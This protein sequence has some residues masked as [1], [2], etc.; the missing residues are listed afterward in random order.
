MANQF[1]VRFNKFRE[2]VNL[3]IYDV[4]PKVLRK[5]RLVSVPLSILA[6]V[7][8]LAFH[9]FQLAEWQQDWVQLI[10][11]VT[12]G[13]YIFKYL[14][15]IF[16]S[17]E[18][19]Q[20]IKDTRWEALLM[21]YMIIN[22]VSINVF[23]FELIS[24]VGLAV[25]IKEL[26]AFFMVLVQ[27]YFL[28]F[29]ALEI[30]KATRLLPNLKLSPA[31]MLVIS[32]LGFMIIGAGL[33]MLPEMSTGPG[34]MDFMD[35]LFTSVSAVSVTGLNVIDIT[36][37]LSFKGHL[38]V[39]ILI[40]IGGLNFITFA[41]ML[42]MLA[43]PSM[44]MRITSMFGSS[45]GSQG[46]ANST[47]L[48]KLIIRFSL[49]FELV[50]AVFLFFSW[51]H[52]EFATIGD[53]IF[54]SI[55]HAVSAFNNAG[56][57]LIPDGMANP[58]I[59]QNTPFVVIIGMAIILGGLGFTAIHDLFSTRAHKNRRKNP[60]VHIAVNTKIAVYAMAILIP[61]GMLIFAL[62]E[63]GVTLAGMT[64]GEKM[65]T[66]F[67]QSVTL[68]TAGFN[69]VDIG[70]LGLSTLL[71]FMVFMF[72]GGSSG[73]TAG[74]I[75]TSTFTLV[76]LNAW[77]T[78]RGRD[79]V[80]FAK[81]TIP[82]ELLNMAASVFLFSASSIFL[83]TIL[84]SFTD[85]HLGLS[86]LA[87]EQISAFCTVGLSTGITPDLSTGGQIILMTSMLIGRV[88]TVTLAFA[89]TSGTKKASKDYQYPKA[90]VQVG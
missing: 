86:R 14:V 61:T 3:G 54:Y 43:N 5:L 19:W 12:I 84:L 52:F 6:V 74:G 11:Q 88:G 33:L 18:P 4:K 25:G 38:I 34:S 26:D 75:K 73:S 42:A 59:A 44:S 1:K 15:D 60:W 65:L 87:F 37:I 89:L 66:S 56:F 78:I 40:Q 23:D 72:I 47:E 81:T 9:G 67:F 8:L 7:S 64:Y 50:T 53:Q 76:F 45:S 13:F 41:S 90:N 83:G 58:L 51:G 63:N 48:L 27:I 10:L 29:V 70:S 68:R 36:E 17:F 30:G 85:G 80:E 49:F 62:T 39:M 28:L 55:F 22:I 24:K 31:A 35:A 20:F 82:V 69:T 16:F 79:R 71:I 32:F 57:S 46:L 21:L 2:W 77:A